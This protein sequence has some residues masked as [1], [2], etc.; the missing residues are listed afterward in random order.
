MIIPPQDLPLRPGNN[1]QGMI[2]QLVML[3]SLGGP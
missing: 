1:P 3:M 2:N